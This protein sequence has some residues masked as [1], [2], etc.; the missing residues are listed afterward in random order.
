[1]KKAERQIVFDKCNGKCAYCGCN[2][3][4]RWHVDHVDPVERLY[5]RIGGNFVTKDTGLEATEDDISN[6]NYKRLPE[7]IVVV[8]YGKPENDTLE[9]MM[10]ACPSCNINKHS[11]NLEEFRAFIE[12]FVVSLN[13]TN[14]QYKVAKRYGLIQETTIPVQFYFETLEHK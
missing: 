2:L 6:G 11:M 3:P 13:K 9:N 10:P 1:M 7:R 8:G 14:V 12:R 5:R 4:E